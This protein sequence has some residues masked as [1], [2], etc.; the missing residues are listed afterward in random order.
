MCKIFLNYT[1][2]SVGEYRFDILYD[3]RL[4]NA[5]T[6]HSCGKPVDLRTDLCADVA[7]LR[8]ILEQ[9]SEI[10]DLSNL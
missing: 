7:R 10:I 8:P 1:P 2:R 4:D 3:P 9:D 6:L 5:N